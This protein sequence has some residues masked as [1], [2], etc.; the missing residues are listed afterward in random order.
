VDA[1]TA[2]V[3]VATLARRLASDRP[4]VVL[5]VRWTPTVR[6]ADDGG[7]LLAG[8]DR[9]A[10]LA[11]H[12]PGAVFCDLDADLAGPPGEG[13]RHPLPTRA[14][15]TASLRRWGVSPTTSVVVHDTGSGPPLAAARAWWV[16]RWAGHADVRVLDGGLAAW[17]AAGHPLEPGEVV[18]EPADDAAVHTGSMPVV[19]LDELVA[20]V[21]STGAV[22]GSF[23]D[24]RAAERFSG[25]TEP[26]D[27]V[28]GH[29]PG[30]TNLPVD[31]LVGPDGRLLDGDGL[32]S[33]LGDLVSAPVGEVT[34]SCGSGVAA[35]VLVLALHEVGVDAALFP[36]SWSQWVRDPSRPVQVDP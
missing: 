17:T 18:R 27:P 29:V 23:V 16:L 34:A 19:G 26:V 36:G 5:D 30:A 25:R 12:L 8:S 31:R 20:Q 6:R 10:Y 32:R 35:A 28:A 11:G 22:D 7:S 33:A 9:D 21:A 4:P 14:D 24:V 2:L 1:G 3:D 13:G 15:L